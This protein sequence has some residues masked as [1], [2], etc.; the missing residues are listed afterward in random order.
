MLIIKPLV[1]YCKETNEKINELN[2][3]VNPEEK[4]IKNPSDP[5][6]EERKFDIGK[7]E[8]EDGPVL[9]QEDHEK[10]YEFNIATHENNDFSELIIWQIIKTIEF[11]LGTVSNT[12]SY[13]RLWALSL[14]HSQLSDIF[15]K[16]TVGLILKQHEK[17]HFVNVYYLCVINI[18]YLSLI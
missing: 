16:A 15:F 3:K 8:K 14:A 13:L 12:A 7:I 1:K 9:Q 18:R 4:L 10:E 6:F 17:V 5:N 2:I 11:A